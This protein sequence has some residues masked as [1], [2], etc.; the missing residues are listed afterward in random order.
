M[1]IKPLMYVK[2]LQQ[3]LLILSELFH[4][5]T[6]QLFPVSSLRL[7]N[8]GLLDRKVY[9][10]MSP[11]THTSHQSHCKVSSSCPQA[12][13]QEA[14]LAGSRIHAVLVVNSDVF[15]LLN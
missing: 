14:I 15:S 5:P 10:P 11:V 13:S 6:G 8:C 1:F 7:Y 3:S 4:N 2:P 9:H 12:N